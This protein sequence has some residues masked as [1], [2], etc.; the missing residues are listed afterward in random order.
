MSVRLGTLSQGSAAQF[1]G[2]AERIGETLRYSVELTRGAAAI[3]DEWTLSQINSRPDTVLAAPEGS[4]LLV[5]F[6]RS[7][8]HSVFTWSHPQDRP[9]AVIDRDATNTEPSIDATPLS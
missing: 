9:N 1:T 5:L 2:T 6:V 8:G 3:T 4:Q 7:L